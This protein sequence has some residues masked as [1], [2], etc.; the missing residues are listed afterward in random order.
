M[1]KSKKNTIADV[2][3]PKRRGR[4]AGAKTY[5]KKTL[6]K[7]VKQYKPTNMVLWATIAEQYR[8]ACGELEARPA[9]VIKKFFVTK[10][11]NSMRK[12]TGS[13][14]ID[15]MTAKSQSLQRSLHQI[16]EGDTFGDELEDDEVFE[17][18]SEPSV[19]DSDSDDS[20]EDI[21]GPDED[22]I[23]SHAEV[24]EKLK[25]V[26]VPSPQTSSVTK[27]TIPALD[28][29]SKNAKPNQKSRLNVG[30]CLYLLYILELIYF[31]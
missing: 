17:E 29:K 10:M 1:G 31:L 7:L 27:V 23:A 8:V 26:V 11:C 2:E 21:L 6:Y 19:S 24:V 14:G 28:T 22:N 9:A 12:P 13:S 16:E 30:K 5:N 15:D 20:D 25:N 18:G 4:A 3:V